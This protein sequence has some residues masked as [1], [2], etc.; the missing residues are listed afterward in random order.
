MSKIKSVQIQGDRLKLNL[1]DDRVEEGKFLMPTN[2]PAEVRLLG[3]TDSYDPASQQ[4]F[5][6]SLPLA[7]IKE[8]SFD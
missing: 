6:F 2:Q 8:I 3:I 4:V 7:R 1:R 5:D